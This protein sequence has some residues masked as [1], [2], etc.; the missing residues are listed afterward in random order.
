MTNP[1]P[2]DRIGIEV[3]GRYDWIS[4]RQDKE[5]KNYS[6]VSHKPLAEDE[7]CRYGKIYKVEAI[8]DYTFRTLSERDD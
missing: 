7:L 6:R 5:W 4:H 2:Q 1:I 8:D 3:R